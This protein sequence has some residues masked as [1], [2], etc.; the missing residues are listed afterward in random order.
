MAGLLLFTAVIC[1]F[2]TGYIAQGKG[3]SFGGYFFVGFLLLFIGV[4]IAIVVQPAAGAANLRQDPL[5]A[6]GQQKVFRRQYFDGQSWTD[7][8]V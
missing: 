8:P 4:V 3:L 2:I 6:P 1:G 5:T 7:R